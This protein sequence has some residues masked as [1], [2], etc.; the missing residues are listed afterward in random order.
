MN[1]AKLA[2]I[3]L[4]LATAGAAAQTGAAADLK[5]SQPPV[6]PAFDTKHLIAIEMPSYVALRFG[7]DPA[8][9]SITPDGVV[10]YVVVA[11]SASGS[12]NAMYEGIRCDA[13]EVKT[14]ARYTA[15]GQW[16]IID[17]PQWQDLNGNLPSR[18]ALALARQGLCEG[19]A[20]AANSAS[21]L[22]KALKNPNPKLF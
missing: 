13:G 14:F 22:I 3:S 11:N 10:S 17:D 7:I 15:S 6:P 4:V 19:R 21:A 18:H 1:L 12:V 5:A 20:V 9:L 16:I 8:T 2:G